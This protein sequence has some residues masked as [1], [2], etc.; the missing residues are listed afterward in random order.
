MQKHLNMKKR[1]RADCSDYSFFSYLEE[2]RECHIS[3]E[4]FKWQ[5]VMHRLGI[6]SFQ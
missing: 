6:V 5:L 3:L 1:G 2:Q 4:T